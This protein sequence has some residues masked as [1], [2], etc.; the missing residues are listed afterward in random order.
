MKPV[1]SSLVALAIAIA[2]LSV[3][4]KPTHHANGKA[5][6][7]K[8]VKHKAEKIVEKTDKCEKSEKAVVR[9][10]AGKKDG[11][12]IKNV[13]HHAH[14]VDVSGGGHG[15]P[16][17]E[18][19]VLVAASM[20]TPIAHGKAQTNTAAKSGREEMPKLP[21]PKAG[22]PSKDWPGKKTRPWMPP[23]APGP[24]PNFSPACPH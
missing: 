4:A 14:N 2:P 17:V 19:G 7:A 13:A 20:K 10:K 9:V 11:A 6:H 23:S 1:V 8:V 15:E 5:S 22:K 21:S 24:S 16:K 3:M 18:K 12:I